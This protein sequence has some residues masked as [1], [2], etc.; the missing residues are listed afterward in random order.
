MTTLSNKLHSTLPRKSKILQFGEGNFLRAFFEVAIQQMN[1]QK[2]T[3]YGV[4]IINSFP[5]THV[6]LN[7]QD[8]LYT[9]VE[10]SA[11]NRKNTIIDCVQSHLGIV[12]EFQQYLDTA[13]DL[14]INIVVSNTT[15]SGIV[16]V[17]ESKECP[18][19]FPA[20]LAIWL[21]TRFDSLQKKGLSD[22]VFILPCEL[23]ENNGTTL[24]S[25]VLQHIN[26]WGESLECI[27]WIES[28]SFYNT[29]VDRIVPG[30][31]HNFIDE[32]QKEWNYED[33]YAVLAE[34]FF[35]FVIQGDTDELDKILPFSQLSLNIIYT[36]NLSFYRDRKVVV[37]NGAHSLLVSI[38]LLLNKKFVVDSLSDPLLSDFLS[39]YLYQDVMS[40]LEG[41]ES[42]KK[43]IKSIFS[44][45]ENPFL[46]HKWD[47]IA[48]N[49]LAKF[50]TRNMPVLL[51][52]NSK[53]SYCGLFAL[54]ALWCF[55]TKAER[56]DTDYNKFQNIY[57]KSTTDKELI[58]NLI[59]DKTLYPFD[60][61]SHWEEILLH[62]YKSISQDPEQALMTL[63]D[64][65]KK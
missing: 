34:E 31:P 50:N 7:T 46:E 6:D 18:T 37:L 49:S 43:Y 14:D 61:P 41:D 58:H 16:Y 57:D 13:I 32:L 24:R 45:F 51:G 23:I 60:I 39:K 36:D 47:S 64:E 4:T 52:M 63:L 44:R 27:Q 21:C 56:N 3:D 12:E 9:L 20:R 59:S 33:K 1:Q 28:C 25:H 48:L 65:E 10:S 35:L 54:A 22:K 30:Y 53:T 42:T 38:S 55:Y 2:L 15:E 8:C 5:I 19:S 17:K 11:T 62:Y 26:D 40:Y 29:L